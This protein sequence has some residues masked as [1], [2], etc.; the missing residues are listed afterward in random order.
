M[1]S[2]SVAATSSVATPR[3]PID[4]MPGGTRHQITTPTGLV[5]RVVSNFA[6]WCRVRRHIDALYKAT[7]SCSQRRH[8]NDMEPGGISPR[9]QEHYVSRDRES[10]HASIS[11]VMR[12][13]AMSMSVML[14][15][16]RTP[17]AR[18]EACI[19]SMPTWT[20]PRQSQHSAVVA[21]P[22]R[23]KARG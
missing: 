13:R 9:V 17:A 22:C 12:H 1:F 23:G 20:S 18:I 6:C 19:H 16:P 21:R 8:T 4:A 14:R 5:A 2:R 10:A 15:T 11:G 3:S 7:W